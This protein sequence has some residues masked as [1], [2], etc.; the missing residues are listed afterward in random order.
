MP[1]GSPFLL[2]IFP[3]SLPRDSVVPED[4]FLETFVCHLP[5]YAS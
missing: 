2:P 4:G 1:E 5:D 3:M